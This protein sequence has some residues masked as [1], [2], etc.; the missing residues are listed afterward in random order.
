MR[1]VGV[2]LT[3]LQPIRHYK[4]TR[5]EF[6]R[7]IPFALENLKLFLIFNKRNQSPFF[8]YE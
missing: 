1:S 7:R 2:L 4:K 6:T 8:N 3:A 5:F